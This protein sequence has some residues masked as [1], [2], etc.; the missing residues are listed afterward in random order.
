MTPHER[1]A[2]VLAHGCPYV[3]ATRGDII[4]G[5]AY[6]GAFGSRSAY[7]F[8]VENTVYLD[9]N[10]ARSG[11]GRLLMERVIADCGSSGF[12]QMIAVI[13]D[14]NP[15]SVAFHAAL[16]FSPVGRMQRVGFKFGRWLDTTLMQRGLGAHQ[17]RSG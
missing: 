15:A 12:R 4:V 5:F 14:E 8:T 7:R 3:V 16:G 17:Q 6:A 13:G 10:A 2:V 9:P 11:I 1:R